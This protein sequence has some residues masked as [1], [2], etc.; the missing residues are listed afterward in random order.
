MKKGDFIIIAVVLLAA[1][2][3][4]SL[5]FFCGTSGKTVIIKQNNVVVE[6]LPISENNTVTLSGNTVQIKNGEVS[7]IKANCKN[8]ICRKHTAI[9]KVG[10]SIVCLPNKV[11]VTIEN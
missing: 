9:S 3:V 4:F 5:F 11:I 6:T 2:I 10:E 8:Q 7:V 1:V